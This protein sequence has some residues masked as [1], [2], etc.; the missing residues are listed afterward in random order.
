MKLL[1][2]KFLCLATGA[3]VL[4]VVSHSAWAQAYPARPITI[5]VPFAPGGLTDAIGRILADRMRASLGQPAVI[6]KLEG[7]SALAALPVRRRMATRS[8][9]ANGLRMW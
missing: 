6:M 5:I 1:R 2:R 9:L 3:V 7:P 8:I 4:P